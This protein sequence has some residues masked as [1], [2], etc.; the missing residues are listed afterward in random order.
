MNIDSI[1][2]AL[3]DQSKTFNARIEGL[4]N[5]LKVKTVELSR[6]DD[7]LVTSGGDQENLEGAS[8]GCDP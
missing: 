1:T 6:M 2:M 3:V 5:E 4:E 8:S 7:F